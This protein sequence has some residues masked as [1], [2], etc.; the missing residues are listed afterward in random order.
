VVLVSV[1]ISL[2]SRGLGG[3]ASATRIHKYIMA[4]GLLAVVLVLAVSQLGRF[5]TATPEAGGG[6][7]SLGRVLSLQDPRRV[8]A[9]ASSIELISSDLPTLLIGSDSTAYSEILF[10]RLGEGDIIIAPHNLFLNAAVLTGLPGV[11]LVVLLLFGL[12]KLGRTV[13]RLTS[14]HDSSVRWVGIGAFYGLLAYVINAQFHNSG[15]V[16]G[17]AMPWWLIGLMIAIVTNLREQDRLEA[18]NSNE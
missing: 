17:D 15:F 4:V 3:R 11:L 14:A 7:Y 12:W 1:V 10:R 18:Q 2:G 8:Q 6:G 16:S 5:Q 9:A 13:I